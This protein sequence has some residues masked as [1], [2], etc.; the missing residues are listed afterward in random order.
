MLK[1]TGLDGGKTEA[2]QIQDH[3][4]AIN[5]TK[6]ARDGEFIM[7]TLAAKRTALQEL[8]ALYGS[9]KAFKTH[10]KTYIDSN[11][12]NPEDRPEGF[13]ELSEGSIQKF[14]DMELARWRKNGKK[15]N[16]N[17]LKTV[18]M[19]GAS[20]RIM[21]RGQIKD[22]NVTQPVPVLSE[23]EGVCCGPCEPCN[24]VCPCCAGGVISTEQDPMTKTYIYKLCEEGGR[25]DTE[26]IQSEEYRGHTKFTFGLS[27]PAKSGPFK[28][29]NTLVLDHIANGPEIMAKFEEWW[30]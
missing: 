1:D 2:A 24:D 21:R 15:V 23:E 22:V 10:L 5:A 25:P 16:K 8:R 11:Y 17:D 13:I 19:P 27:E 26:D 3:T 4:K 14:E 18:E 9:G 12:R 30:M 28:G 29:Q 20:I 7:A 6:G